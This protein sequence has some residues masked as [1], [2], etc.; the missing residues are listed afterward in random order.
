V[1][2]PRAVAV[3][4]T[5]AILGVFVFVYTSLL[6][7]APLEPGETVGGLVSVTAYPRELVLIAAAASV[8]IG[9]FVFSR[10]GLRSGGFISGAYIALVAPR[11]LD[12]V[13]ASV[14]AVATWFV[15]VHL[16]MPRL[17]L[18]G[19]RKRRREIAKLLETLMEG[20]T[21]LVIAHRLATIQGADRIVVMDGGRI[22]EEGTHA[23]LVGAGGLY[24]RLAQLQLFAGQKANPVL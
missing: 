21:T 23:S 5:T 15:V 20:R 10:L 6:E 24:A 17:L 9:M 7:I 13:F 3:L 19:R 18:F 12:L 11:W 8:L 16:L 14:V 1:T 22:V 2:R 4:G